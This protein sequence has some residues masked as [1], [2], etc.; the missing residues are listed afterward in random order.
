[1]SDVK[2]IHKTRRLSTGSVDNLGNLWIKNTGL[3]TAE[4]EPV[5]RLWI[6]SGM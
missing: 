6:T 5:D 3:S 2:V 1:M 4:R